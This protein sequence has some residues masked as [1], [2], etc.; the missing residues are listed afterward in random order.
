VIL[1]CKFSNLKSKNIFFSY[2]SHQAN[3]WAI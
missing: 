1:I 3:K 2:N